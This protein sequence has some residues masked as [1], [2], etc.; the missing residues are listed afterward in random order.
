MMKLILLPIS[1]ILLSVG[2][3]PENPEALLERQYQPDTEY[4]TSLR[5]ESTRSLHLEMP[6]SSLQALMPES[7]QTTVTRQILRVGPLVNGRC[8]VELEV[9]EYYFTQ[10]GERSRMHLGGC[11]GLGRYDQASRRLEWLGLRDSLWQAPALQDSAWQVQALGVGDA[12]AY[13]A[14]TLNLLNAALADSSRRLLPGQA[15][16]ES[17]RQETTIG[18]WPVAWTELRTVTLR[19]VAGAEAIFDVAVS[20]QPEQVA[21]GPALRMEGS[22]K[23]RMDFDLTRRFTTANVMDT[24]MTIEIPDSTVTWIARSSTH[25]DI[26]TDSKQIGKPK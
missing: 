26:R 23:G 6:D 13:L 25:M 17:S 18:P 11:V 15:W 21:H 2:C 5:M 20:L 19:A 10:P 8:A 22:G 3:K 24:E 4:I 16:Q 1:L 12:A 14:S 7:R 9:P